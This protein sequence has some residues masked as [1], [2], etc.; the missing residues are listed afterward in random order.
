MLSDTPK[1]ATSAA[2]GTFPAGNSDVPQNLQRL[3]RLANL[4]LLSASVAH[5]IKNG[6]VAVNTFCQVM[7]EK[8]ESREMA[9]MVHRELKRID[10]LVTQMLRLAAPKAA[11]LEA[12]DLHELLDLTLRLLDHQ[13]S[14][15][16]ITVR[17]H[18][19]A[20][21]STV[22]ADESLLQQALMNLLLNAIEAMGQGG[23][24][25]AATENCNGRLK[26][27]IRDTGAGIPAENFGQIFDT[28]FTT[29]K[30][31]TG[32]GLAIARRVINDHHGLIE[33]QSEVGRGSTFSI[34]LPLA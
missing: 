5:E 7:M 11:N 21:Q 16:L 22:F 14:N 1:N 24:L 26:I 9:D 6:L 3:D 12:V 8:E 17:R 32:L 20:A 29:K 34:T 33:V 2:T 13:L 27:S 4:G 15:R 31:G 19:G 10:G 30:Q 23:E 25:T 18:Y 28:F